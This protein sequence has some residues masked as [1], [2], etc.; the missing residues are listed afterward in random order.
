MNTKTTN[1]SNEIKTAE[2]EYYKSQTENNKLIKEQQK[3]SKELVEAQ[4]SFKEANLT[5]TSQI[6][7]MDALKNKLVQ[8]NS[9]I[10]KQNITPQTIDEKELSSNFVVTNKRVNLRATPNIPSKIK[11]II[12]SNKKLRL[13]NEGVDWVEVSTESNVRGFIFKEYLNFNIKKDKQSI[14][15]SLPENIN[16][17]AKNDLLL[18]V[19]VYSNLTSGEKL[20]V[21]KDAN[22]RELASSFS[23]IV[24]VVKKGEIVFFDSVLRGWIKVTTSSQDIGYIDSKYLYVVN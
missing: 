9:D 20:S 14:K 4:L 16:E 10:N 1:L 7:E 12:D 3:I 11:Y 17:N 2:E 22:I 21:S 8:L 19:K 23:N 13:V 6:N 15:K 5:I 18:T 24:N